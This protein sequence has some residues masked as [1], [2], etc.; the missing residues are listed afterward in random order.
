M[1]R[2]RARVA[3]LEGGEVLKGKDPDAPVEPDKPAVEP[4]PEPTEPD[5]D[6]SEPGSPVA[7]NPT[8]APAPEPEPVVK[9][10]P[11]PEPAPEPEPAPKPEPTTGPVP[12]D[13]SKYLASIKKDPFDTSAYEGYAQCALARKEYKALIKRLKVGLRDNPSFDKG[14]YF[15][16][17]A[18]AG[19]DEAEKAK[20]AYAKAC[21][22]GVNE[23]CSKF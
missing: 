7:A 8:P 23:A 10:E 13:C 22:K 21:K 20:F 4:E 11:A 12:A 1:E 16:G 15:I 6:D 14:W 5:P 17:E 2:A 9:P 19:L 18:Q 3:S